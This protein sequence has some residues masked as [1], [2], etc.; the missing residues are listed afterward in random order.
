[1]IKILIIDDH[2]VVRMGMRQFLAGTDD[3][4]ITGEAACG[5]DG[6]TAALQGDFDVAILD[7]TLPDMNGM[8]VLKKIR[9]K[10]PTL[11]VLV[12]SM[13]P[14]E[15]FTL[16]ALAAGASG[17]LSKD[18]PPEQVLAAIRTVAG[19]LRYAS[20]FLTEKL[21]AGSILTGRQLP[22]DALSRR[23]MEVMVLLSKGIPL[24]DVGKQ[25]HLSVKTVSTYRGRVLEKL[26]L[27]SNAELTR[28]V[29][30]HKLG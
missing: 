30:E 29:I 18:S 11:P 19:G 25:L 7:L 3:V 16:P 12:F 8:E 24:T 13:L 6:L 1:M 22:H 28:Y 5:E 17:Y 14:E 4:T 9:H 23:E 2:A 15:D 10:N 21:L 27:A 26:D 20:P